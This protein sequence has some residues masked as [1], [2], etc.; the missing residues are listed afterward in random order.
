MDVALDVEGAA[1]EMV[2]AVSSTMHSGE[3]DS[4]TRTFPFLDAV[5]RSG[6]CRRIG[7]RDLSGVRDRSGVRRIGD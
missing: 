4:R 1:L 5:S 7:V 2:G 3:E 6:E